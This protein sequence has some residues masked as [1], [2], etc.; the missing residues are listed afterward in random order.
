MHK[1]KI[2]TNVSK[3]YNLNVKKNKAINEQQ[4]HE[5]CQMLESLN[6][7]NKEIADKFRCSTGTIDA[8]KSGKAWKNISCHLTPEL[9]P[10]VR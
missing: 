6:Y 10:S 5:I 1:G 7:T 4:A 2:W 3:N 9:L 8:I